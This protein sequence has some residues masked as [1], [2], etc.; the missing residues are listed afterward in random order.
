[1]IGTLGGIIFTTSSFMVLTP[2]GF[3]RSVSSRWATHELIGGRPKTQY[4]G[5]GLQS[6][7][8]EMTLKADYGVRPRLMLEILARM[9]ESPLAYPLIIG[10]RPVGDHNWRVVS[11]SETYNVVYNFGELA[12]ATVQVSLEEYV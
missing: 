3:Q 1:M 5:P 11:V 12:S 6:V 2:K 4:I 8:F 9:C 7:S 10:G